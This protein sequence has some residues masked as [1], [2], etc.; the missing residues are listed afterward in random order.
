MRIAL[1]G[2]SGLAVAVAAD[3]MDK[4]HG[5]S[6]FS[7]AGDKLGE[8]LAIVTVL[9]LPLAALLGFLALRR[10]VESER[11]LAAH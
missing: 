10:L 1:V 2:S 7:P 8:A 3:L 4:G 5:L 11:R 6:V 9:V